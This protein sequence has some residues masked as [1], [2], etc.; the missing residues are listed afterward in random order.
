MRDPIEVGRFHVACAIGAELGAK[1]VNRD[2]EDVGAFGG[3]T[4]G[5]Q[6]HGDAQESE[7]SHGEEGPGDEGGAEGAWGP[8][9]REKGAHGAAFFFFRPDLAGGAEA[10][11]GLAVTAGI[12]AAMACWMARCSGR[13]ARLVHSCGSLAES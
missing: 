5:K 2:E 8:G 3:V 9:W 4:R 13:P 11:A 1:I 6:G 10:S 7:G 12:L